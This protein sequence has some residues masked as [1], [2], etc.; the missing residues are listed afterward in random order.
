MQKDG[1]AENSQSDV[2]EID[3]EAPPKKQKTSSTTEEVSTEPAAPLAI[4][5][6]GVHK[7]L[8]MVKAI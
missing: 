5:Q 6:E 4:N 1:S 2:I 7:E 3:D 8:T